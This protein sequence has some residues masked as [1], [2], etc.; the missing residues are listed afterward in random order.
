MKTLKLFE[1]PIYG[2]TKEKLKERVEKKIA[3]YKYG[4][5][6]E[7][8]QLALIEL[9]SYPMSLWEYNHIVGYIQIIYN[10]DQCTFFYELYM[11]K[12]KLSRYLW[13]SKRKHFVVNQGANG[14]HFYVIESMSNHDISQRINS[15]LIAM[16]H[17]LIPNQYY[18]DFTA[19]NNINC[20]LDYKSIIKNAKM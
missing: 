18:V 7:K 2:V 20:Y 15:D 1:I 17:E 11:P 10:V 3:P 6:D 9:T 4:K 13:N 8:T 12:T 5:Y 16:V 14:Q 19:F